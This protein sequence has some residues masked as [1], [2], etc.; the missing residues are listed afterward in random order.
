MGKEIV[1]GVFGEFG[2]VFPGKNMADDVAAAEDDGGGKKRARGSLQHSQ[3]RVLDQK[4]LMQEKRFTD[5]EI[6]KQ[7]I[8]SATVLVVLPDQNNFFVPVLYHDNIIQKFMRADILHRYDFLELHCFLDSTLFTK[9]DAIFASQHPAVR[10]VTAKDY[11]DVIDSQLISPLFNATRSHGH[12]KLPHVNYAIAAFMQEE[13]TYSLDDD[14]QFTD[15]SPVFRFV[16]QD[17]ILTCFQSD[18]NRLAKFIAANFD[19]IMECHDNRVFSRDYLPVNDSPIFEPYIDWLSMLC[20]KLSVKIYPSVLHDTWFYEQTVL[21]NKVLI[22]SSLPKMY[23]ELPRTMHVPS[24]END[25]D[26]MVEWEHISWD[27]FHTFVSGQLKKNCT[28]RD[29]SLKKSD[30]L[31]LKP[32]HGSQIPSDNLAILGVR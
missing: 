31:V 1:T 21:R 29:P 6:M 16:T 22:G 3:G 26:E 7:Q 24:V 13:L 19:C 8:A 14:D 5:E 28:R 15:V 23:L 10:N 32:I 12:Y 4:E 27:D 11:E 20:M 17:S 2:A 18:G 9:M 30:N 25:Q